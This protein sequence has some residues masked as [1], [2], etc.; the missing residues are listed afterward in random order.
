MMEN[1]TG[2]SRIEE[3]FDNILAVMQLL[4][5]ALVIWGIFYLIGKNSGVTP[6][7]SY[8]LDK[9]VYGTVLKI[10][11]V[12][13]LT[14]MGFKEE[15]VEISLLRDCEVVGT[16]DAPP[17]CPKSSDSSQVVTLSIPKE[18]MF[19]PE[20]QVGDYIATRWTCKESDPNSCIFF[21]YADAM[22]GSREE[23]IH[24]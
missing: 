15:L 12:Q 3:W 19:G 22:S 9:V 2:K 7:P 21:K 10:D 5:C 23:G 11:T 18:K 13:G 1:K 4:V 20:I 24:K 17:D 8:S 16:F 14:P 6:Q